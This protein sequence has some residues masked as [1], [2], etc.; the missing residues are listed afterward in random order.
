M[1]EN[2]LALGYIDHGKMRLQFN[3]DRSGLVKTIARLGGIYLILSG[4]IV[5]IYT[6][7]FGAADLFGMYRKGIH[8]GSKVK[9][10]MENPIES[11]R[12]QFLFNVFSINYIFFMCVI[13]WMND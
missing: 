4:W 11:N 9:G 13:V 7:F 3:F 5:S 2:E 1:F 6:A 10:I 8:R 12:S